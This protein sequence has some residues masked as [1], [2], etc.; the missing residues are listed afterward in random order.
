[1]S[2]TRLHKLDIRLDHGVVFALPLAGPAVRSAAAVVDMMVVIVI[3]NL[4][5]LLAML[6]ALFSTDLS[7]A[8][9][10]FLGFFFST[11]YY[12]VTEWRTGQTLGK[13][14]MR[15][16]VID[17]RGLPL[18]FS[19][20]LLRN[21]LRVVDAMPVAYLVGGLVC[22]LNRR[23]QR[24]GDIAA[25][26]VVVHSRQTRAPRLDDILDETP[27]SFRSRPDLEARLRQKTGP[28][29]A[30]LI[31]TAIRRRDELDPAARFELYR[32]LAARIRA[33]MALSGEE[34]AGIPDEQI[35]RNT[36][37]TLFNG[38]TPAAARGARR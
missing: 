34:F 36:L 35:L 9:R 10:V 1:M 28:E 26:T 4:T 19:Q 5:G 15:L 31:L 12:I 3:L 30:D 6:L 21:L 22:F 23:C 14:L 16:R 20:I 7:T 25:G 8:A 24:V 11:A 18:Q 38:A 27:N 33:T 37:D 32:R 29:E 17:E 2:N 13:R